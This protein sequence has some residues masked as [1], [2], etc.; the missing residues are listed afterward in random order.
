V[1]VHM[2]V[3]YVTRSLLCMFICLF[4]Y[5]TRSLLCMFIC[6]FLYVTRSLLCMFICLFLYVTRSLLCVDKVSLCAHSILNVTSNTRH[7][8]TPVSS[9]NVNEGVCVHSRMCMCAF[10]NVYVCIQ[11]CVCVHSR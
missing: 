8:R 5:V 6:L 10:K 11:E 1:Y 3:L 2:S 7:T 9:L 4:L